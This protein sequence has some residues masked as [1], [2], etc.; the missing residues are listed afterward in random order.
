MEMSIHMTE[1]TTA[2]NTREWAGV[3]IP[4]A[5]T[6]RLDSAHTTVGFVATHM[7]FT[8]VRGRFADLTGTVTLAEDPTRSTIDVTIKT[9]SVTTGADDRDAHLRSADF[10]DVEKYPEMTFRST[11]IRHV[12]G[13]EFVVIG[14]LTIR[15]VTRQVELAA[16]FEGAGTNPFGAEV[17]GVSARTEVNREDWGLTWNAALETG[18]VLVGKKVILEIE[19]Q[20]ARA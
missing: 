15:G 10:F 3:A 11:E 13:P 16:T 19:A 2:A 17:A 5:G 18:G 4:A 1:T 12:S 14:D 9:A 6:F 8:K 20:A 7:M